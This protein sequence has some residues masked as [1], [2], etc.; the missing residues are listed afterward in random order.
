MS[1][2][3]QRRR[4]TSRRTRRYREAGEGKA[5]RLRPRL[6]RRRSA[7]GDGVVDP[8]PPGYRCFAPDWPIGAPADRDEARRRPLPYGVAATIASFLEALDLTDVTIVGND[9]GGHVAG[10]RHSHPRDGSAAS[11]SPTGDTHENF[12]PGVQGDAADRRPPGGMTLL[13]A[14]FRIGAVGPRRPSSP[15]QDEDPTGADRLLDGA[16][17][18]RSRVRHD[19]KK[20]DHRNETTSAH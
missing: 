16:G 1:Q 6:P 2:Q 4:S 5:V 9:S 3:T 13:A 8:S 19:L 7:S 11:S 17:D 10:P 12:P 14:P 18:A 20:V 15:S